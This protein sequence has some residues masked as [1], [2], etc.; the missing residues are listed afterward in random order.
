MN[1]WDF[2]TVVIIV[3]AL[4]AERVAPVIAADRDK[5][6]RHAKD[7]AALAPAPGAPGEGGGGEP[8]GC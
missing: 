7:M 8:V 5:D 1:G 4:L 2:G 6:R 3:L